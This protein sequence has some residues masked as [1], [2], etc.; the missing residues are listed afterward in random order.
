MVTSAKIKISIIFAFL[1]LSTAT[2]GAGEKMEFGAFAGTSYYLGDINPGKH[3]YSLSPAFGGTFKYNFND[4]YSLRKSVNY[5]SIT[6]DDNDF[7]NDFQQMRGASFQSGFYDFTL[8][9]EFNFFPFE[10]TIFK[11]GFSPYLTGGFSYMF[12]PEDSYISSSHVNIPFGGGFKF[13]ISKK[14][15]VGAEWLFKK[16]LSDEIDGV[17]N[18]GQKNDPSLIHN[19]DWVSLAGFFITIK[20]FEKRGDCPVYW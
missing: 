3:F 18:F 2:E 13:G 20:P 4:H 6:G 17:M 10:T 15:T 5:G 8:L 16:F 11:K 12:I 19:N 14:I 1:I 7:E 9:L